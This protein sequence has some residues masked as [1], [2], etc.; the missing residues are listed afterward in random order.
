MSTESNV[1]DV[2]ALSAVGRSRN[3]KVFLD[4]VGP[5]VR[6]FLLERG[7]QGPRTTLAT[8]NDAQ[9][10]W[11]YERNR[12]DLAK[13]YDAAK[14]SQWNGDTDLDW[15]IQVDP[16]DERYELIPDA[17][18]PLTDVPEY[19][20]LPKHTQQTHRW[21]LTS[22][23]LSQFLHGE[24]GAL[25]AACQVTEAVEWLDGKLYGSTQVVDEGRHV[26]VFHRYLDEKLGKLYPINDNLYTII[27]ALMTDGRWDLKFLGMQ[28]MIEGLALGAFGTL[29]QGTREPLLRELLKY[30]IT[31]EARHVTFGVIA[32]RDYYGRIAERERREREDWAYEI[33]VLLRNRFL[34]HEFYDEYYAHV[35]PRRRWDKLVLGSTFMQRFRDTMFRRLIPNL[36]RIG[37]LGDRVRRHYERLG[38]LAF[39]HLPAAP[40]LTAA[41]MFG[42]DGNPV[43]AV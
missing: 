40:D 28:I 2:S 17:W 42:D 37:L 20:T 33:T 11:D 7:K 26:E 38:L 36:R 34:G 41:E 21:A 14:R 29:R 5:A 24:Q 1:R 23:I 15:S 25:F 31:D 18:L 19:R 22:W 39:E 16:H 32:L 13:L 4:L 27:D 9:F 10:V 12:A 6:G 35:M 3:P 30:V 43:G 8:R